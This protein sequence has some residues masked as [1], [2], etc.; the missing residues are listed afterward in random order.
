M[1]NIKE[2]ISKRKRWLLYHTV[3]K[4]SSYIIHNRKK[5]LTSI[6]D[7][8]NNIRENIKDSK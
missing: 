2:E 8:L 1:N 5:K 3:I 7:K 6:K 4:P